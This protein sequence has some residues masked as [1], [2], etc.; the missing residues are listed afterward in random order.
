MPLEDI[1]EYINFCDNQGV[2]GYIMANTSG[3]KKGL[4]DEHPAH[5]IKGGLSGK[6][7]Y[8]HVRTLVK[9]TREQTDSPIIAS[10]G[11]DSAEKAVEL[12]D[13]GANAFQIY[14]PVI[15]KGPGIINQINRGVITEMENRDYNDIRD[16]QKT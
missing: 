6:P 3:A 13:D 9:T 16:F 14:T 11:I 7:L 8:Q 10:G 12:L 15:Y 2:Y 4:S 5:K 1:P